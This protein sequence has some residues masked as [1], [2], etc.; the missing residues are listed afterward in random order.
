MKQFSLYRLA[1][2]ILVM[3][4]LILLALAIFARG[5]LNIALP[6]VFIVFGAG[7]IFLAG[8]FKAD[9]RWSSV[10]YLPAYLLIAFGIIFLLNVI[11][12]DWKAWAYAWLLLVAGLGLGILF[13]QRDLSWPTYWRWVGL[14]CTAAG[15]TFF[16]LFG[17][18]AGGLLIQI[19]APII[20]VAA[21]FLFYRMNSVNRMSANK[22][23]SGSSLWIDGSTPEGQSSLVE[24]LSGR[25]I[26]VMRLIEQGLTNQQIAARLTV[27]ESTIKTHINNIY[28][29]LGVQTRAQAI[30]RCRSLGIIQ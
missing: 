30:K 23:P 2:I 28:G 26:E 13:V 9:H 14:G 21:G 16:V 19:L 3:I 27:A 1:S 24:G 8:Y 6:L 15:M 17:A 11:T 22:N 20:L 25:E 12:G 18:I 5:S 29:K 7:F 4:G 10:L